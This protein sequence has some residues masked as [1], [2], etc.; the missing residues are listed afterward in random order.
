MSYNSNED[1]CTK[2]GCIG[3]II[4]FIIQLSYGLFVESNLH[5]NIYFAYS[6]AI[7]TTIFSIYYGF[8]NVK[9]KKG[10]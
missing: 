5:H 8:L 9:Q 2:L 10:S 7:T 6:L 1:G 3:G 4:L